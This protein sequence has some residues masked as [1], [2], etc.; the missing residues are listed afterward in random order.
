MRV[1]KA[2]CSWVKSFT[3]SSANRCAI[4]RCWDRG[5]AYVFFKTSR[6]R[7]TSNTWNSPAM[8]SPWAWNTAFTR[9]C[10]PTEAHLE[11]SIDFSSRPSC[12]EARNERGSSTLKSPLRSKSAWTTERISCR[13]GSPCGG[14]R[15]IG[16][17]CTFGFEMSMTGLCAIAAEEARRRLVHNN[18]G[19]RVTLVPRSREAASRPEVELQSIVA[20][21]PLQV[22][23][24]RGELSR[25]LDGEDEGLIE[26]LVVA[27]LGDDVLDDGPVLGHVDDHGGVQ[28]HA[29]AL[30]DDGRDHVV[31]LDGIVHFREVLVAFLGGGG[32][33]FRGSGRQSFAVGIG[34]LVGGGAGGRAGESLP[35]QLGSRGRARRG[36]G[37]L[38]GR[39]RFY[40]RG[41]R[42]R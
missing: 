8:R 37:R 2:P 34:L 20:G 36:R 41:R 38:A 39:G 18:A 28:V 31:R 14:A 13:A 23:R 5:S 17:A 32:G 35:H 29:L 25:L 12:G 10:A 4:C 40:P 1:S 15:A 30:G 26:E 6:V 19:R 24:R 16:Y 22:P 7:G 9:P 21:D 42:C 27:R 33:V 3:T 11:K